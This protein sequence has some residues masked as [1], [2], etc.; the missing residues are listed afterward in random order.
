MEVQLPQ[1]E[2]IVRQYL[3]SASTVQ[4]EFRMGYVRNLLE[5]QR[6]PEALAQLQIVTRDEPEFM[7]GWLVLGSLQLQDDALAPAEASF[8]RYVGLAERL[9]AGFSGAGPDC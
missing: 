5:A 9:G 7:Q 8:K 4:P 1:A 3:A 2:A 6:Y